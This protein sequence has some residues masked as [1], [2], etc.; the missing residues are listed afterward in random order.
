MTKIWTVSD[1]PS[2]PFESPSL[3]C[4]Y[5]HHYC[6]VWASVS[7][8]PTSACATWILP[9]DLGLLVDTKAWEAM[10]ILSESVYA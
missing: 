10:E 4:L 2:A 5:S 6:S 9:H 3:T 1:N 8:I 7:F